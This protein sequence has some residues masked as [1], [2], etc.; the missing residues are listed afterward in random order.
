MGDNVPINHPERV[1]VNLIEKYINQ[2]LKAHAGGVGAAVTLLIAD[3]QA[4]GGHLTGNQ[5]L[6]IL[7]AYLGVGAVI[8]VAPNSKPA[9]DVPAD[10]ATQE[11]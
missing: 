7:A 3:L 4:N 9:A 8:A 1:A 5:G 11:D 10:D 2:F 6:A